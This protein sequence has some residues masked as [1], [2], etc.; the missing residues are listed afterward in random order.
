MEI[1]NHPLSIQTIC[2]NDHINYIRS[3]IE[4]QKNIEL[5]TN[6]EKGI[7]TYNQ[8]KKILFDVTIHHPHIMSFLL[9]GK[10]NICETDLCN[11]L[12]HESRCNNTQKNNNDEEEIINKKGMLDNINKIKTMFNVV[13]KTNIYKIAILTNE[14]NIKLTDIDMKLKYITN[15]KKSNLR[16]NLIFN[17][18]NAIFLSINNY[19]LTNPYDLC[20]P[21][22]S[23]D[24]MFE[25]QNMPVLINMLTDSIAFY[26]NVVQGNNNNIEQN[27]I[28]KKYNHIIT[29]VIQESNRL[30]ELIHKFD[31]ATKNINNFLFSN[32]NLK[33]A[34]I[35]SY[36]LP[37]INQIVKIMKLYPDN[38]EHKQNKLL[39]NI[40]NH[41]YHIIIDNN[42]ITTIEEN[43]NDSIND[44]MISMQNF[45]NTPNKNTIS[46]LKKNIKLSINYQMIMIYEEQF[47]NENIASMYEFIEFYNKIFND[48]HDIIDKLNIFMAENYRILICNILNN[49]SAKEYNYKINDPL[50]KFRFDTEDADKYIQLIKKLNR[51]LSNER[52]E[53][54]YNIIIQQI[55]EYTSTNINI[56]N[57]E[58]DELNI[59]IKNI[60]TDKIINNV[61]CDKKNARE[62]IH[63]YNICMCMQKSALLDKLN[64][65]IQIR[66]IPYNYFK[67]KYTE[68]I[69]NKI[70]ENINEQRKKKLSLF[71][72][73]IDETL[74]YSDSVI[75]CKKDTIYNFNKMENEDVN[76]MVNKILYLTNI[77]NEYSLLVNKYKECT[78][79]YVIAYNNVYSYT[80]YIILLAI[81]QFF[82]ENYTMYIYLNKNIVEYYKKRIN[83]IIKDMDDDILNPRTIHIKKYY[84]VIIRKLSIFLNE[85]SKYMTDS[86]DLL[87]VRNM[88]I[89]PSFI[90]NNNNICISNI[91]IDMILFNYFKPIIESY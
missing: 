87:D 23:N 26:S 10:S 8:I 69:Y 5:I 13:N 53:Y 80:R 66:L 1:I 34:A 20:S 37:K 57:C 19:D 28:N 12:Y 32:N 74:K 51:L 76:I 59:H 67:K 56:N 64:L 72:N 7:N 33:F 81:N 89:T 48:D 78:N 52:I 6:Y 65:P 86:G 70:F 36:M 71:K 35:R 82:T 3:G 2:I 62:F 38:N 50:F 43:I 79:E 17:N 63:L 4:Y 15:K 29:N 68:K 18:L 90:K 55:S 25:C 44:I 46:A 22:S 91:S 39:K 31:F 27:Q 45:I 88:D 9:D 84:N 77:K 41:Y 49:K 11:E 54:N 30:N 60:M 47:D 75:I 61:I 24:F 83:I 16:P 73:T 40:I 14:L 85:I 42:N 21:I 58:I